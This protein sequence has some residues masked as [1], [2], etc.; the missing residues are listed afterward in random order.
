MQI[1]CAGT[2]FHV[3]NSHGMSGVILENILTFFILIKQFTDFFGY[4]SFCQPARAIIL[5][6][7]PLQCFFLAV[8]FY[9]TGTEVDI[10]CQSRVDSA[11]INYKLAVN[12][13][14]EIIITG[15]LKNDIVSPCIESA[16]RLY[17]RCLEFHS[18]VVIRCIFILVIS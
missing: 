6:K 3:E 2:S 10:S 11:K 18:V 8:Y 14:P 12:I 15:E 17:K 1:G 5:F 7:Y 9:L 13:K 4:L 16:D